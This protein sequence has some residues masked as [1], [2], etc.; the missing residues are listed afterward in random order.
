M[1][2]RAHLTSDGVWCGCLQVVETLGHNVHRL[3][4]VDP[5][6][7]H[8][9]KGVISQSKVLNYLATDKEACAQLATVTLERFVDTEK[10][11]VIGCES[12][13]SFRDALV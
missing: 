7:I 1:C 3:C 13:A 10:H 12:L 2:R 8:N 11:P 4:V 5:A 9:V 6:N